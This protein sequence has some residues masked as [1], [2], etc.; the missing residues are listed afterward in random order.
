MA[1][2]RLLM[3]SDE[4]DRS[5]LIR[6]TVEKKLRQQEAA[7]RLGVW[8]RHFKRLV[9]TWKQSGDA[10]LV[11]RQRGQPSNRRLGAVNWP[12][13]TGQVVKRDSRV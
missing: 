8:L 13:K 5:R 1:E 11:S 12:P 10:G 7:E 2:G 3:S 4:R 6:E 9:R